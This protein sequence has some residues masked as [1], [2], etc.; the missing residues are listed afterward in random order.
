M[1]NTKAKTPKE[2]TQ[3]K[4]ATA[5]PKVFVSYARQTADHSNWVESLA[6]NLRHS[7]IDALLDKWHVPAG[8]DFTLFMDQIRQCDRVLLV[9]TPEYARKANEGEGGVG[10]ERGIVTAELAKSIHTDKF[11][12]LLR[13]GEWNEA[14]PTFAQTKRYIDFREDAE[15]DVQLEELLRALHETPARPAPPIGDTPVREER[16][17]GHRPNPIQHVAQARGD[18]LDPVQIAKKAEALN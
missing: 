14:A 9:C 15:Y 11:V 16:A 17:E 18:D 2:D 3:P 12:P 6:C 1:A 7:G 4:E 13:T 10:Y 5:P 8:G